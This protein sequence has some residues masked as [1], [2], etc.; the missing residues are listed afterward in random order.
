MLRI[1]EHAT[2]SYT[3]VLDSQPTHEVTVTINSPTG[4]EIVTVQPRLTF[5]TED[6]DKE[7]SVTVIAN[8]DRDTSDDYG[9]ITHTVDSLQQDRPRRGR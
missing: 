2:S 1:A 5:T 4:T 3:M 9:V 6:W 7:Q 8:P